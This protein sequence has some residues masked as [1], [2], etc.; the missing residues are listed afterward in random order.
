MLSDTELRKEATQELLLEHPQ[1]LGPVVAGVGLALVFGASAAELS[2]FQSVQSLLIGALYLAIGTYCFC[3]RDRLSLDVVARTYHRHRGF[4]LT[5]REARGSF[6]DLDGVVLTRPYRWWSF[7]WESPKKWQ[8]QLAFRSRGELVNLEAQV[9]ESTAY[10]RL[11]HFASLLDLPAFDRTGG[12]ER[13]LFDAT[14]GTETGSLAESPGE[15]PHGTAPA[16]DE[17]A[18]P[19]IDG[20]PE[21]ATA[22]P[23]AAERIAVVGDPPVGSGIELAGAPGRQKILLPP[24]LPRRFLIVAGLLIV[25][26]LAVGT[27]YLYSAVESIPERLGSPPVAFTLLGL[28]W[29]ALAVGVWRV[30]M[31]FV[32]RRFQIEHLGNFLRFSTLLAGRARRAHVLHR[33]EIREIDLRLPILGRG[34]ERRELFIRSR[35]GILRLGSHLDRR[36]LDWLLKAVCTMAERD[37]AAAA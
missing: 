1:W 23:A 29:L 13:R 4:F 24:V 12:D 17:E 5:P 30:S 3:L 32:R 33:R 19:P 22:R 21:L 9:D 8:I 11:E 26:T 20:S 15:E 2:P 36:S 10:A 16:V 34:P 14:A 37:R 7:F 28:L 27:T 25:A 6:D 18:A 31:R 35:R